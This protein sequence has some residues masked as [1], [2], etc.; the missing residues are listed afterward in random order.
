MTTNGKRIHSITI[1]RMIDES[2]DTSY[3][4]E[5]SSKPSS[6]YSIDRAHDLDCPQ[7]T[8]NRPTA[9]IDLLE[10]VMQHI[11]NVKD[12]HCSTVKNR[13]GFQRESDMDIWSSYDDAE[14]ILSD[15]SQ[16]VENECTCGN[17]SDQ[18]NNRRYRYFNPSGNYTNDTPSNIVKYTRQDY[19]R[20]EALNKGDWHYIGI[21]AEAEYSIGS[22]MQQLSSGG[23]W[24]T[25]S[26]SDKD[27]LKSVEQEELTELRNQLAAI[28]FSKRAIASAMKN[29]EGTH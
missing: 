7:Q 12:A 5:Y 8:Y 4:G 23:L 21:R 16:E 10:Q 27:Y 28:G 25:E 11:R 9:T 1:K 26:D 20:M 6:E 15:A 17:Y 18:W 19:E 22:V 13:T 14:D 24:S 2:P 3:L 29:I